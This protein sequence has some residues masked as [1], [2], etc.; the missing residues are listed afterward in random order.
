LNGYWESVSPEES[1]FLM[2]FRGRSALFHLLKALG[3]GPGDEVA[4]QAFTCLA[5]PLPVLAVGARPVWIDV[6]PNDLGMD[7]EDLARKIGPAT[8]AV[9]VQ[10]TFGITA[11][12][13]KLKALAER[14]G[15]C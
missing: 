3:I 8:K 2:F 14:V 12:I 13:I 4:V 15:Q 1:G 11:D 9:I 5:V 7:V 6:N 10:H